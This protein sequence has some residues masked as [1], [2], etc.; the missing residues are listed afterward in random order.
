MAVPRFLVVLFV[1]LFWV[2]CSS[3]TGGTN[4]AT[5]RSN[6]H[7]DPTLGPAAGNPSGAST[8]PSD[9]AAA[10]VSSP[11]HVLGTGTP[12]SITEAAFR[13]AVAAGGVITFNGG[14]APFT[15]TLTQT[16]KVFNNQADVV[17]D[18]GGL[19]TLSGGGNVRILYESTRDPSQVW[20][21][22]HAEN[23]DHPH[24]T[25][26]NLTF[27]DGWAGEADG[28]EVSGGGAIYDYGGRLK[29]VNCRFFNNGAVTEGPDVGGGAV[30]AFAQYNSLPVYVV[31]STFGGP[32]GYGNSASNGGALSSI[33]VNWAIYN[34]LFTGNSAVGYRGNPADSGTPGG[35]SGGAIY[36]DGNNLTLAI[37][38]SKIES[39]TGRAYGSAIFFVADNN[40][41]TIHLED[42]TVRL[43][44]GTT[45]DTA[46]HRGISFLDT[47]TF[48]KVNSTV[49]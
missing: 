22:T 38:G 28:S 39:N 47:T 46:A 21:T 26:Q 31:N 27:V 34:S 43:N 32:S 42:S 2:G 33:G 3:P 4:S 11:A 14:T 8:V 24:L 7:T 45:W 5:T 49:E 10:D 35:G 19:V 16:A 13:A 23:Q 20:T 41:G 6:P 12:G 18:G 36:N 1:A 25:V 30:R 48:E 44:T 15:I 17:I 9:G 37:Y 29:I 40:V